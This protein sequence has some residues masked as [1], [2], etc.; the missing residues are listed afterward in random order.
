MTI[1]IPVYNGE[2][3]L[4]EAVESVLAQ[5]FVDFEIVISDNASTDGTR[6]ISEE[7]ARLDNRV[8]YVRNQCNLGAARNF[9]NVVR[10]ARGTYFKWLCHDDYL[11]PTFLEDSV[12]WLKADESAT[13]VAPPVILH[14]ADG[15]SAEIIG[16]RLH[17][18]SADL[19]EQHRQM[20]EFMQIEGDRMLM[21]RYVGGLHRMRGLRRTR[22]VGNYLASDAVLSSEL[23]LVGRIVDIDSSASYMR[24]HE[25]RTYQGTHDLVTAPERRVPGPIFMHRR[26]LEY[27]RAVIRSQLPVG[28]KM[29]ALRSSMLPLWHR[30]RHGFAV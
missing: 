23:S 29:R 15:T 30:I 16:Q 9:N 11:A 28:A 7:F 19:V 25:P 5:T 14:S 2:R 12:R 21:V 27:P 26:Y 3:Y 18:W 1:G 10:L 4:A 24:V 6:R 17:P 20:L 8:R 13:T 22:L